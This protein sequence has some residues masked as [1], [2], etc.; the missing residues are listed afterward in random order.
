MATILGV[1]I[2]EELLRLGFWHA[3]IFEAA[4]LLTTA[5]VIFALIRSQIR[6]GLAPIE[7]ARMRDQMVVTCILSLS[8]LSDLTL[9]VYARSQS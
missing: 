1:Y 4:R 3:A 6:V 8:A 5:G 9:W 2:L 7:A